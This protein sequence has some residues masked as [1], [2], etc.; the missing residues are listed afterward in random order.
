MGIESIGGFKWYSYFNNVLSMHDHGVSFH[1]F[2]SSI[3]F[4][5]IIVLNVEIF[6]RLG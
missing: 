4:I 5:C 3:S 1:L 2:Y 6:Q